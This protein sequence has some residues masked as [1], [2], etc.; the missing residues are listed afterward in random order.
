MENLDSFY[1]KFDGSYYFFIAIILA[2]GTVITSI[3]FYIQVD[4]TFTITTHYIS[5]LGAT[6]V[7][8]QG[9]QLYL[10]A[11]VF[12]F[13]MTILVIFRILTLLFL[14]RYL[15]IRGAPRIL[16]RIGI[17]MGII[18][19]I[20]S[21]IVAVIPFTLSLLIH[22]LGALVL[23]LGTVISGIVFIIIEI[24]TLEIPKYLPITLLINV[25]GYI[26]FATLLIGEFMNIAPDGSSVIWEWIIF[27][28][29]LFWLL[30]H[31]VYTYKNPVII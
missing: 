1:K 14:V 17:I 12:S 28:T 9:G 3:V 20:G 26:I 21:L 5:H 11:V 7:G 16:T 22:E 6:P 24:K 27:A 19:T 15:Q 31:G 29:S 10:S 2:L 30:V 4:P 23:F 25:I 18:P 8:A 13:G